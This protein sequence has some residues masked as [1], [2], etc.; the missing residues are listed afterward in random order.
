[1][2]SGRIR[3]WTMGGCLTLGLI[4]ISGTGQ[5]AEY[6]LAPDGND[7]GTGSQSAPWKTFSQAAQKLRA[8]DTL[9]VADGD[10]PVS[11]AINVPNGMVDNRIVIRAQN[12]GGAALIGRGTQ[13]QAGIWMG[14]H[15]T[16]A[17]FVMRDLRWPYNGQ[18]TPGSVNMVGV[19]GVLLEDLDISGGE[20]GVMG[21]GDA[22]NNTIRRVHVHHCGIAPG[23]SVR[24][25]AGGGFWF[26][27]F[28]DSLIEDCES[29]YNEDLT[30]T[31]M[32]RADGFSTWQSEGLV[33]R[34]CYAHHNRE[35]GFDLDSPT[36]L[37]GCISEFNAQKG[38]KFWRGGTM[39]NCVSWNNE[40][41]ITI[42]GTPS[43]GPSE[44]RNCTIAYNGFDLFPGSE[45]DVGMG[46]VANSG[47]K[48][49][50][51]GS[52]VANNQPAKQAIWLMGSSSD[53]VE[54]KGNLFWT[55]G[56]NIIQSSDAAIT[57]ANYSSSWQ[58][59]TRGAGSIVADPKFKNLLEFDLRLAED[60]P[61]IN[62]A[63]ANGAPHVDV[64]NI[65]RPQ[66]D[67]VD[68]GAY[69]LCQSASCAPDQEPGDD[70][71]GEEPEDDVG[72][73]NEDPDTGAIPDDQ[74]DTDVDDPDSGTEP[75]GNGND[76][77]DTG[78][79][80]N[81]DAGMTGDSGTVDEQNN[82]SG[83]SDRQDNPRS[84]G[85]SM[86]GSTIAGNGQPTIPAMA[87]LL[88]LALTWI[89]PMGLRRKEQ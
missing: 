75:D 59:G 13:E 40:V 17:G 77:D 58:N 3:K 2:L 84:K 18:S 64:D 32:S 7:S 11:G 72:I 79:T 54:E 81:N 70:E 86:G 37:E 61:A 33:F 16:M 83:T 71:P 22:R 34:R 28:H 50:L 51:I 42:L 9:T 35:E 19:Q 62:G 29:S 6:F 60:S 47:A 14:N 57:A 15:T 89:I 46:I 30:P 25:A 48:I 39:I 10:Y 24:Q 55:T 31:E 63:P 53:L 82:D 45:R 1:M 4:L 27:S 12:V 26:Y 68:I 66:G 36:L 44:I 88:L 85:C 69:E 38:F 80:D 87:I 67:G 56:K 73:G 76:G 20:V 23:E 52:I 21:S 8:G 49:R 41:G 43:D 74:P 5:A 65:L 78:T